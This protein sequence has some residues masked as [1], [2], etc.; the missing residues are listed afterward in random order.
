MRSL[1]YDSKILPMAENDS[2]QID[3]LWKT[4]FVLNIFH[5]LFLKGYIQIYLFLVNL[6][7][8][9]LLNQEY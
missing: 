3:G 1:G 6:A 5:F 4:F 8:F 2:L 7:T 9:Y